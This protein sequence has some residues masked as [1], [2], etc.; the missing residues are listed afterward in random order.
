MLIA[1]NDRG[2]DIQ[3]VSICQGAFS[4]HRLLFND[5]NFIFVRDTWQGYE[6]VKEINRCF[7]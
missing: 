7:E 4:I 2:G 3:G 6:V 5:D 1:S